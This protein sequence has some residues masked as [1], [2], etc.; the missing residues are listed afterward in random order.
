MGRFKCRTPGVRGL[1]VRSIKVELA[2]ETVGGGAKPTS[3]AR[4]VSVVAGSTTVA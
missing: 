3:A 1:Y 2:D 4:G